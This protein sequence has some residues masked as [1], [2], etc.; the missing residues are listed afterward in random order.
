[1]KLIVH[2]TDDRSTDMNFQFN[3]LV[4]EVFCPVENET[5]C[6]AEASNLYQVVLTDSLVSSLNFSFVL[7]INSLKIIVCRIFM[8]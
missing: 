4:E 8:E 6:V 2:G 1:M 7:Y 5:I 3:N